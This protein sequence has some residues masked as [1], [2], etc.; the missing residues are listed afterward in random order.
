MSCKGNRT[1]RIVRTGCIAAII[2]SIVFG[3]IGYI[4]PHFGQK[5]TY[6]ASET[7]N[8]IAK[9]GGNDAQTTKNSLNANSAND[10]TEYLRTSDLR[11]E[12]LDSAGVSKEDSSD[13]SIE[14]LHVANT[15]MI[16]LSV[17]GPNKDVVQTMLG[18]AISKV[19]QTGT[20]Y[21]N[22]ETIEELSSSMQEKTS[23][24]TASPKKNAVLFACAGFVVGV[25]LTIA[26]YTLDPRVRSRRDAEEVADYPV[27]GHISIH[28]I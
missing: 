24:S 23:S 6:V 8:A 26:Y 9:S 22:L 19:R 12:L 20:K 1:K 16:T 4:S 7:F 27:V 3:V 25:F 5:E 13:Y 14:A 11:N 28:S 17:I 18:E 15:K 21:F 2:C 10:L